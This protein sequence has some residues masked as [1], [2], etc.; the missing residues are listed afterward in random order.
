MLLR[1]MLKPPHRYKVGK[2]V[3]KGADHLLMMT[4]GATHA[5][6]VCRTLTALIDTGAQVNLVRRGLFSHALFG[7][8]SNPRTL[9][10][11]S[12]ERME[13]G[14]L[15]VQLTMHLRV[16][17]TGQEWS[18]QATFYEA[19]IQMDA[20]IGYPWLKAHKL[21]VVACKDTLAVFLQ[22][23]LLLGHYTVTTQRRRHKDRKKMQ[24]HAIS[25]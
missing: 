8:S 2:V 11:A 19:D 1:R 25:E 13:G 23:P 21:A 5:G 12:G 4:L 15:E 3:C 14:Q 7:P 10:T 6:G 20:I 16:R 17:G 9:I 22:P 18:A 24:V